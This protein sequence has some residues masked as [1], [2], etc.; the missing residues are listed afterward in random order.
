MGAKRALDILIFSASFGGGH[1]S[2]AA[3]LEDYLRARHGDECSVEVVDFF[4]RFA[5]SLNVL[6]KFAYHQSVQ[7]FPQLYGTFFELTSRYPDSPVVRELTRVGFDA[8][9]RYLAQRQP[10]AIVSFYPLAGAVAAEAKHVG[11]KETG[12]SPGSQPY[13]ATVITDYGAH[14][15]WIHPA[16]D[17]YFVA[18]KDVKDALAAQGVPWDRL[19][20]TGIPIRMRFADPPTR[21]EARRRHGLAEGFTVLLMGG[22]MGIGDMRDLAEAIAGLGVETVAVAG[23]N[24]KLFSQLKEIARRF[25]RVR[26]LGWSEDV[27]DLMAAADLLVGRAGGLTV[28]EA[29]AVGLPQIVISPI[30]GQELFNVDFLVNWGAALAARDVEDARG[31]VDFLTHHPERLTELASNAMRLGRPEATKQLGERV[32]AAARQRVAR[33]E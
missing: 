17:D 2:A 31:K 18:I 14:A 19:H 8:A 21:E 11:L 29:T 7:F 16:T 24:Q 10:D 23:A 5:P 27:P 30:P 20:A 6:A 3:A 28:A 25:G 33:S 22:G 9:T 12:V 15:Q 1:K 13:C 4:E 32:L 26:A